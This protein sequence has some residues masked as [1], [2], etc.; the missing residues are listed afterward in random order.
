MLSVG[1]RARLDTDR[2]MRELNER[3]AHGWEVVKSSVDGYRLKR[4]KSRAS[5]CSDG[6]VYGVCEMSRSGRVRWSYPD[7]VSWKSGGDGSKPGGSEELRVRRAPHDQRSDRFERAFAEVWCLAGD[8]EHGGGC[9]DR[10][11]YPP[12]SD[13]RRADGRQ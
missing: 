6:T 10:D 3:G 1:F 13:L 4:R 8:A 9:R 11:V 2:E 5:R 7:N 12:R